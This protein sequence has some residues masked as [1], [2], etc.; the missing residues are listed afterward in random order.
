MKWLTV[1]IVER[2]RNGLVEPELTDAM[3]RLERKTVSILDT[4]FV[5]LFAK[6]LEMLATKIS[7]LFLAVCKS[8]VV[9]FAVT[10]RHYRCI[11]Q[12]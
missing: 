5:L 3:H 2:H 12:P 6:K 7:K 9:E 8:I 10:W 4:L 1:E 11:L